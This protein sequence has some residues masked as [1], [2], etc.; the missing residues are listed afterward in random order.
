MHP[1][2][3]ITFHFN[4]ILTISILSRIKPIPKNGI[5]NLTN[6]L[7]GINNEANDNKIVA[8]T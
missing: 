5:K 2:V 7:P 8:T 3:M 4:L 1:N 6:S